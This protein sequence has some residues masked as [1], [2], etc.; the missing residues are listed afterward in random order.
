MPTPE[1]TNYQITA[2]GPTSLCDT[3][4]L[5]DWK[6]F[7]EQVLKTCSSNYAG[8]HNLNWGVIKM[9]LQTRSLENLRKKFVELNVTMRQVGVDEEKQFVD[10]RIL[11]GERL[12]NK[13]YQPFLVQYA[14]RGV[15]SALR[16][17]V[18][19]KILYADITQKEM[20]YFSSLSEYNAG[21][22]LVLDDLI[23][24]D[25]IEICNDDKYFIFQDI[26]ESCVMLFFRDR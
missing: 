20:D 2:S 5:Y 7:Y 15:P 18:Y 9:N 8:N 4:S 12:L 26:M 19:K 3:A 11:M 10:E 21:W 25:I 24:S 16:A 13:D 22:E 14:K 23:L 6:T 1:A 17:R